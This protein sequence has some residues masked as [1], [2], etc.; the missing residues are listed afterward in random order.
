MDIVKDGETGLLVPE[1]D[2]QRL[3]EAINKILKNGELAANL[4]KQVN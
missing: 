4:D 1:K 3:A 2:P